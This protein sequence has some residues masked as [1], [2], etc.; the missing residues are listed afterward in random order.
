MMKSKH[1]FLSKCI[2]RS[3]HIW[4][5]NCDA[6][7]PWHAFAHLEV[8]VDIRGMEIK[9]IESYNHYRRQTTQLCVVPWA[10]KRIMKPRSSN[11]YVGILMILVHS[12]LT[13]SDPFSTDPQNVDKKCIDTRFWVHTTNKQTPYHS[14]HYIV[15][16]L[17][18][19]SIIK[20]N[21]CGSTCCPWPFRCSTD[22]FK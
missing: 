11:I 20:H 10:T 18:F 21:Y 7:T 17:S 4:G 3:I 13:F 9:S 5:L 1:S 2:Y 8:L 15:C 16:L 19:T 14:G 6:I 22:C 12:S